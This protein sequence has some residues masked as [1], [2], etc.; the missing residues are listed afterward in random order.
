MFHMPRGDTPNGRFA[1]DLESKDVNA[2]SI[3]DNNAMLTSNYVDDRTVSIHK[4]ED[5]FGFV[6]RV[7]AGDCDCQ[8]FRS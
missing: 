6:A 2:K 3:S 5:P 1:I 8:S 7:S 4:D